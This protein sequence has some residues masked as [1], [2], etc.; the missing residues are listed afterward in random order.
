VSEKS[1]FSHRRRKLRMMVMK[2]KGTKEGK[3]PRRWAGRIL[4]YGWGCMKAEE[5]TSDNTKDEPW[6]IKLCR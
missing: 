1:Y 5:Y 6:S 3:D 2:A 4:L